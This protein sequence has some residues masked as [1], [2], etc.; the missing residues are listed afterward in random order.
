MILSIKPARIKGLLYSQTY[1]NL[2]FLIMY[3]L[4]VESNSLFR[5]AGETGPNRL[6][7]IR[8]LSSASVALL[9]ELAAQREV[10]LRANSI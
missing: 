7:S 5:S 10:E 3:I 6:A 4:D 1:E 8:A 9:L 2:V